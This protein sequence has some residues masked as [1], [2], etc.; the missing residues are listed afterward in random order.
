M[1]IKKYY[2]FITEGKGTIEYTEIDTNEYLSKLYGVADSGIPAYAFD[3]SV[4]Q[5]FI[6]NNWLEFTNAEISE[7]S[8]YFSEVV[9]S[10]DDYYDFNFSGEYSAQITDIKRGKRMNITKVNDEWFY[11]SLF[12]KD[13]FDYYKCDQ[14]YGLISFIKSHI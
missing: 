4:A 11:V 5:S 7:L 10:D 1:N 14:F 8:K 3:D 2:K 13:Q 9:N 12:A 6:N